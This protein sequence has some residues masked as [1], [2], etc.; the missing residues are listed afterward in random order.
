MRA[1]GTGRN[2]SRGN[3]IKEEVTVIYSKNSTI[4]KLEDTETDEPG[5]NNGGNSDSKEKVTEGCSKN[6]SRMRLEHG[7]MEHGQ[8]K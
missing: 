7:H 1:D 8:D 6:P 3:D 2:N 4:M 5:K